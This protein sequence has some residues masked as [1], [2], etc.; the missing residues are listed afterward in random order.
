[1]DIVVCVKQIY[2]L[3][4]IRIKKETREPIL[5]GVPFKLSDMDRNALEEAIRIKEKN[6]AR[7]VVVS[8]GFLKVRETIKGALAMGA[9]EA[10]VV[11]DFAGDSS[12]ASDVLATLIRPMAT[13]LILCGEGSSDN[14]SGQVPPRLA[15]S[16]GLPCITFVR[17]LS[18]EG[19][20]VKAKR[21]LEDC[22][23]IVETEMPCVVSVTSEIN[24]AR[25]P[26]LTQI[27]KASKKPIRE[28]KMVECGTFSKSLESVENL[29]PAT[30]RKNIILEG[31]A[32]E[33]AEQFV[34]SLEKEGVF[35]V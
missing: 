14:Y 27:L 2:D 32:A 10:V 35:N 33:T 25:L 26:S 23:E 19:T 31:G 12:V 3:D 21:D 20:K 28:M 1:M 34:R 22:F 15:E 24:E 5:E 4:Q 6:G 29:A 7:I 11:T 9:D 18:L 17:E 16:L 8:A 30:E 13:N